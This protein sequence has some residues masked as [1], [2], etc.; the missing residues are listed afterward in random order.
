[1]LRENRIHTDT[2]HIATRDDDPYA[3]VE[4]CDTSAAREKRLTEAEM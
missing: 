3:T 4:S 1:M 2:G